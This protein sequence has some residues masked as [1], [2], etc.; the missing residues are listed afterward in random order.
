MTTGYSN[1]CLFFPSLL[2]QF[3]GWPLE[4]PMPIRDEEHNQRKLALWESISPRLNRFLTMEEDVYGRSATETFGGVLSGTISGKVYRELCRGRMKSVTYEKLQAL[5]A[6]LSQAGLLGEFSASTSTFI[7]NTT[8]HQFHL[9][10]Y[11]YDGVLRHVWR[12]HELKFRPLFGCF[13][14]EDDAFD[15]KTNKCRNY[16]VTLYGRDNRWLM[17]WQQ[18]SASSAGASFTQEM[19]S[20][21]MK[22]PPA[23]RL[24]PKVAIHRNDRE[25]FLVAGIG[26]WSDWTDTAILSKT[27]LMNEVVLRQLKLSS[28]ESGHDCPIGDQSVLNGEW[29]RLFNEEY[30][31]IDLIN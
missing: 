28:V 17:F 21:R 14:S 6:A 24:F 16:R 1:D 13:V 26:I 20:A 19:N 2:T 12:H 4:Q 11:A 3:A 22:E 18:K 30:G 7:C 23:G 15:P 10:R 5:D 31:I 25:P 8:F 27:L 9:T 29:K